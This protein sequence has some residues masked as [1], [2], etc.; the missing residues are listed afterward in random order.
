VELEASKID[1]E[2]KM[3]V[4][5]VEARMREECKIIHAEG[6]KSVAEMKALKITTELHGTADA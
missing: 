1:A 2:T 5:E 6:D 4:G 3:N